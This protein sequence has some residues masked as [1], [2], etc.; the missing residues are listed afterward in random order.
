MFFL[1]LTSM[2]RSGGRAREC[3]QGPSWGLVEETLLLCG[4]EEEEEEV[5][6]V[7]EEQQQPEDFWRSQETQLRDGSFSL[8]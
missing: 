4:S 6:A 8:R 2:R 1:L 5:V 7:L 3:E